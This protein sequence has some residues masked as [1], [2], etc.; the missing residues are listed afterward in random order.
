M[1][2]FVAE[3]SHQLKSRNIDIDRLSAYRSRQAGTNLPT[4]EATQA[5]AR[6]VAQHL[7]SLLPSYQ[8]P[9]TSSQQR[10]LELEAEIAKMKGTTHPAEKDDKSSSTTPTPSGTKPIQEALQGRTPAASVFDPASLLVTPGAPCHLLTYNPPD[11]LSD[12]AYKKWLKSLQLT[13]AQME[14]LNKNIEKTMK[15]WKEQ[16]ETA[17]P[18]IHRVFV[19]MGFEATK[20]KPGTVHEVVLKIMTVVMTCAS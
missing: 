20:V 17:V 6:D 16:P 3:L 4:K 8:T 1:T 5:L 15:W 19:G 9:D 10:I 18:T 7:Q 2:V 12:V 11:T 14:T 13:P